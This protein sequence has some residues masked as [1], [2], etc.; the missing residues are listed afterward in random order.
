MV[1]FHSLKLRYESVVDNGVSHRDGV[2]LVDFMHELYE[3]G[4]CQDQETSA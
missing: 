4:A 3:Q 1:S 2:M